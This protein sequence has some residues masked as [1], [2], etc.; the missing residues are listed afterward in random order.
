MNCLTVVLIFI[1]SG[2]QSAYASG[3][4]KGVPLLEAVGGVQGFAQLPDGFNAEEDG[5][6][7]A[8]G[9]LVREGHEDAPVVD[10]EEGAPPPRQR[11]CRINCL[12]LDQGRIGN[13]PTPLAACGFVVG[14]VILIFILLSFKAFMP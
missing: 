6:E 5:V 10:E 3:D 11:R 8:A 1:L 9:Q 7:F 4:D 12:G 2:L 14:G 13:I